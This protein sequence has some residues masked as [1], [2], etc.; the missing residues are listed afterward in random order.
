MMFK[1][2]IGTAMFAAIVWGQ[3]APGTASEPA[4]QRYEPKWESLDRRANPGWYDDEKI[5]IF[6]HW[7]VF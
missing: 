4:V 5:G 3:P 2:M 6:I 7:S 1:G